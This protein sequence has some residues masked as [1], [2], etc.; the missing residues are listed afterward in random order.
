MLIVV[1]AICLLTSVFVAV[2]RRDALSLYLLGISLSNTVMFAGVIVYIAKMGGLAAARP[3]LFF[4]FPGLQ[5]WLQY[6]P[7]PL[8]RLGFTVALGRTLFPLFA[9]LAAL[10]TT[11]IPWLR[12]SAYRWRA[13]AA[14][15]PLLL[16]V[17]NFPP[18]FRWVTN[19]RFYL[20]LWM[21]RLAMVNILLYLGLATVLIA[22][23]YFSI[24]IPFCRRNFRYV[25]L[26]ILSTEALYL[27]YATKDPVQIYNVY[28]AEYIQLGTSTYIGPGMSALGW[29]VL[30]VCTTVFVLFGSYGILRYTQIHYDES[31]QDLRLERKFDTAGTGISVFVHG[32]KNQLLSSRVLHKRLERALAANPPDL[33]T[34]RACAGQLNG[35]TEGML[36]RMDELYQAVRS[37]A[38]TLRPVPVSEV[39]ESAVARFH[40][41][42]PDQEVILAGEADRLVLA[43]APHLSEAVY[44]L[45]IN[46]CEAAQ[47]AGRVPQVCLCLH[48]ERL[49]TVLEVADNGG[50]IPDSLRGKI[51]DPFYTSKN[52]NHNWGM[53]L[54]YVRKIVKSH[55]GSIRLESR[56]GEGSSFFIMLPLYDAQLQGEKRKW[57]KSV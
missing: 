3:A 16:L 48:K 33:A 14:V 54:Y 13:A 18:V 50:G 30:G 55:F 26:S 23:E 40:G 10:E 57:K 38:I 9:L 20:I 56:S 28:I 8:D 22:I 24:S 34:A 31:R 25:V 35:L 29:I 46:G 36:A 51:F 11:M 53:G 2:R 41:K 52:T 7:L 47:Q 44:N 37:N 15:L 6:L 27:P 42:Y 12:R 19:G 45:L 1:L 32:I 5:H 43:D 39:M 21:M 4:L 49:W 17:Y